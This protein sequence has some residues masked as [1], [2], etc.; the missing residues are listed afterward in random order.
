MKQVTRHTCLV[1]RAVRN[2][3]GWTT[4]SEIATKTEVTPRTVR[5][6]VKVLVEEGILD[7]Q[8]VH[9]GFRYRVN[10]T[11]S[12]DAK[13]QSGRILEAEKVFFNQEAA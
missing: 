4:V 7:H 2:A 10:E 12:R 13:L 9:A 5:G 8:P 3:P 11:M 1:Y 6:I